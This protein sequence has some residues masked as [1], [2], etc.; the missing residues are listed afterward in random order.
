MSVCFSSRP[1]CPSAS[2]MKVGQHDFRM[3]LK[4]LKEIMQSNILHNVGS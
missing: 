4:Y 2:L 1:T 3:L